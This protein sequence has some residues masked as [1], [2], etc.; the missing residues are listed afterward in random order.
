MISDDTEGCAAVGKFEDVGAI[1]VQH[2]CVF[3]CRKSPCEAPFAAEVCDGIFG[4]L[5][6]PADAASKFLRFLSIDL[7]WLVLVWHALLV[8]HDERIPYAVLLEEVDS[9]CLQNLLARQGLTGIWADLVVVIGLG[10]I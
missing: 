5:R 7:A 8:V 3:R 10:K 9:L 1:L 2:T 6:V 4:T